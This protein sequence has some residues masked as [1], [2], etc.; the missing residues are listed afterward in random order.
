MRCSHLHPGQVQEDIDPML[1]ITRMRETASFYCFGHGKAA[2]D[3]PL[4]RSPLV[5]PL[6][7]D[8]D[9]LSQLPPIR[10]DVG[11]REALLPDSVQFAERIQ[12]IG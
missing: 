3:H 6:F 5:S 4:K 10:I 8:D 9:A 12:L 7:A 11:T 2:H 1:P